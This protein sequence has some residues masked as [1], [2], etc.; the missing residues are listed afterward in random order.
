MNFLKCVLYSYNGILK[1]S[2]ISILQLHTA[3]GLISE[4]YV[5]Y[6]KE[7]TDKCT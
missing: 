6:K 4:T 3:T 5:E 7:I 1:S 2:K